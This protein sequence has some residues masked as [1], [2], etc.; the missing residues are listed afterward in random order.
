MPH[1]LFMQKNVLAIQKLAWA[2]DFSLLFINQLFFPEIVDVN[3]ALRLL[4]KCQSRGL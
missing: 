4:L 1:L 2:R 3:D